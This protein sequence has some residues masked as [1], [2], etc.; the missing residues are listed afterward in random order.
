MRIL[1][2]EQ[3]FSAGKRVEDFVARSY[4]A[5]LFLTA[6][7]LGLLSF[8]F[9]SRSDYDVVIVR[10]RFLQALAGIVFG[11][12]KPCIRYESLDYHQLFDSARGPHLR[13]TIKQSIEDFY[14]KQL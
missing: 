13:F 7:A 3:F 9:L 2:I 5:P 12:R 10:G 6:K 14:K 11:R 1:H 8:I 4:P